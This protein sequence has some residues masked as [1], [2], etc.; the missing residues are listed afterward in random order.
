MGLTMDAQVVD[1]IEAVFC[2]AFRSALLRIAKV[3]T[4][5]ER[6]DLLNTA[7]YPGIEGSAHSLIG[8][9]SPLFAGHGLLESTCRSRISEI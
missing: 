9:G 4:A 6:T 7:Q 5:R 1:V 2:S 8:R 3:N